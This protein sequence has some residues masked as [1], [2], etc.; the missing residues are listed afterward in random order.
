MSNNTKTCTFMD[1]ICVMMLMHSL[2]SN[3]IFFGE[4]SHGL[5][6]C[7]TEFDGAHRSL[8]SNFLVVTLVVTYEIELIHSHYIYGCSST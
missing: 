2:L 7:C 3:Y 1:T 4:A 6:G 8:G 5:I